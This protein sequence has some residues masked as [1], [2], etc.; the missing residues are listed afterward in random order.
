MKMIYFTLKIFCCLNLTVHMVPHYIKILNDVAT[1]LSCNNIHT[2]KLVK[3]N[4]E[5]E[6][7]IFFFPI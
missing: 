3:S 2:I 4:L 1:Y 6:M 5:F 7:D